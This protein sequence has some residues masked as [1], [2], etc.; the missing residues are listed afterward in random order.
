[1]YCTELHQLG[2]SQLWYLFLLWHSNVNISILI[3][4]LL[5]WYQLALS[6]NILARHIITLTLIWFYIYHDVDLIGYVKLA[7]NFV[8]VLAMIVHFETYYVCYVML[9]LLGEVKYLFVFVIIF[10]TEHY[11]TGNKWHGSISI[12]TVAGLGW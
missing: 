2:V 6:F 7:I 1:M 9:L 5:K 4:F 12:S 10:R 3:Y 11:L 8:S